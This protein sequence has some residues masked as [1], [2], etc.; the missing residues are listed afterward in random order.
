MLGGGCMS[1]RLS[2]G[3]LT[4]FTKE[5]AFRHLPPFDMRGKR[6]LDVGC[7][8]GKDLMHPVYAEAE[9]RWGIDPDER[10]LKEGRSAFPGVKLMHGTAEDLPFEDAHFDVVTA[11][12]S[13]PYT[14]IPVA[15]SQIARVM[16]PDGYLCLSLHDWRRHWLAVKGVRSARRAAD[17]LYVTF[18][19]WCYVVTD[20]IPPRPWSITT[21]ETYQIVAKIRHALA[22]LDFRDITVEKTPE[23]ARCFVTARRAHTK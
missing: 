12:V 15:L 17:M 13:L 11:R 21:R 5:P 10:G 4:S 3:A 1:N 18:A 19:S 14:N 8:N 20:W 2:T 16:K 22:K 7:G 23:A 9:A 6:V